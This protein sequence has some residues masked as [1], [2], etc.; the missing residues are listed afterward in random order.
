MISDELKKVLNKDSARFFMPGHKGRLD[1]IDPFYDIT[2]I[3][4]TD[5]LRNPAA[6][7]LE[8][9][10]KTAKIYG[11]KNSFHLVGGSSL[12]IWASLKLFKDNFGKKLAI[13]KDCHV[14]VKNA[15]EVLNL[16]LK[17]IEQQ[18]IPE[19]GIFGET[20]VNDV[21]KVIKTADGILITSPTYHG[22]ASDLE[23]ISKICVDNGKIFI[24]DAA[25]GAHFAFSDRLPICGVAAGADLVVQST[26]KTLPALTQTAILHSNLKLDREKI[27]KTINLFQ[28][29]SPSYLLLQSIEF[30]VEYMSKNGHKLN[31][32]IDKCD[33]IRAKVPCLKSRFYDTTKLVFDSNI[34][35]LRENNIF[36]EQECFGAFESKANAVLLMASVFNNEKD[37]KMLEEFLETN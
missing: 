37:F 32:I 13:N 31:W 2:E 17:F 28:T 29:T 4:G 22:I 21:E 6:F 23:Q 14:S 16:E 35:K 5:D 19:F 11:A 8:S 24:L 30:A 34:N 7:L 12:G 15:A 25:H 20:L 26:H 36:P 33:R 3:G 27:Q 1:L 18:F 9:Q 10:E